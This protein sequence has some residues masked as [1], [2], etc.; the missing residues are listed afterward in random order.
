MLTTS[1]VTCPLGT[2]ISRRSRPVEGPPRPIG[3]AYSARRLGSVIVDVRP[4]TSHESQSADQDIPRPT[5][6]H[7][8]AIPSILLSRSTPLLAVVSTSLPAYPPAAP[9]QPVWNRYVRLH[10]PPPPGAPTSPTSPRARKQSSASSASAADSAA[11]RPVEDA[12]PKSELLIDMPVR[13]PRQIADLPT[14]TPLLH[15]L[16]SVAPL[17]Q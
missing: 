7:A 6:G 12:S 10:R 15:T 17:R 5:H 11:P 4:W 14:H 16:V 3:E 1:S 8:A 13:T 2:S 9:S